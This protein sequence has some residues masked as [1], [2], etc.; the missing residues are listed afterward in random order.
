MSFLALFVFLR[1]L[2]YGIPVEANE[3]QSLYFSLMVS[4]GAG[5]NTSG[6]VPAVERTL[7]E[8]NSDATIIPGYRLHHTRVADTKVIQ[9]FNH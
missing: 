3:G 1:A 2:F 7:Q 6:V 9:L 8:I 4:G 5:L